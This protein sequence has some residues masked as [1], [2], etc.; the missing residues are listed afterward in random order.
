MSR[1]KIYFENQQFEFHSS[2][3]AT[4]LNDLL[5]ET[6]CCPASNYMFKVNNTNTRTRCVIYSKLTINTPQRCEWR[7]SSVF[8]VNFQCTSH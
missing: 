7:R 2:E 5:K 6:R 8:I 4:E 1:Y 3:Q